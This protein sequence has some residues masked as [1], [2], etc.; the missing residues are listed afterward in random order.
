MKLIYHSFDFLSQQILLF[1]NIEPQSRDKCLSKQ[2]WKVQMVKNDLPP[3]VSLSQNK[4]LSLCLKIY[5]PPETQTPP[6]STTISCYQTPTQQDTTHHGQTQLVNFNLFVFI[7]HGSWVKED[8]RKGG[9]LCVR[10]RDSDNALPI[11]GCFSCVS[12]VY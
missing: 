11:E 8:R 4:T 12:L 10:E 6:F 5:H 1:Q 2:Q 9:V 3:N 7:R